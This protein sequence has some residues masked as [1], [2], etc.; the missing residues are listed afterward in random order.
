MILRASWL[1]HPWNLI[2]AWKE[3]IIICWKNHWRKA[4]AIHSHSLCCPLIILDDL[5]ILYFKWSF[6]ESNDFEVWI[7]WLLM[8][9]KI[10]RHS[11]S[12]QSAA[13]RKASE[14]LTL[15]LHVFVLTVWLHRTTGKVFIEVWSISLR[16]Q[17]WHERGFYW[18]GLK[19][20]P[21]N[22]LEPRVL[23]DL[24]RSCWSNTV[25]W[26]FLQ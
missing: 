10:A 21:V 20:I 17:N 5:L 24:W 3:S 7:L 2:V 19:G 25:L 26:I 1:K 9:V 23:L 4:M 13:K 18:S 12:T 15:F 16:C 22:F 8:K 11:L 6:M 14:V